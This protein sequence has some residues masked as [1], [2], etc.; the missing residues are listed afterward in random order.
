MIL[1][2]IDRNHIFKAFSLK[3]V[4]ALK[5]KTF[6]IFK[7]KFNLYYKLM[8]AILIFVYAMTRNTF[9]SYRGKI[10]VEHYLGDGT[11]FKQYTTTLPF[12]TQT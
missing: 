6:T 10:L 8:L 3:H 5:D 1:K 9:L 2:T 12:P 7:W 4:A 11:A